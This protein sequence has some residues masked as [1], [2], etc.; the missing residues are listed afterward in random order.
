MTPPRPRGNPKG[1]IRG[2]AVRA[3]LLRLLG[4]RGKAEM[5]TLMETTGLSRPSIFR[6][7]GVLAAQGRITSYLTRKGMVS[8]WQQSRD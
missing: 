4:R 6:H 7:L 1:R 2:E 3:V 8:T 5:A